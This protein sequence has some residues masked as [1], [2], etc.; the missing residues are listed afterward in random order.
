MDTTIPKKIL[1]CPLDWGIGHASRCVPIIN[2]LIENNCNV[3]IAAD[4][5]PLAFLKKEF[6]DLAYIKFPGYEVSYLH[7][8]SMTLKILSSIPK[9]LRGIYR[10]NKFLKII[11]KRHQIDAVI[12]D[13]RFGLWNRNVRCVYLTHQV[14]IKTSWN[15][16]ILD[17]LLYKI[18]KFFIKKYNECWIPDYEG[19]VN[20]SGD[21]SHK[22]KKHGNTFFIGPLSRFQSSFSV[23]ESKIKLSPDY[24][25]D[26]LAM[27]SGPEPQRTIFEEKIIAELKK[28]K[29]KAIVLRGVT[30]KEEQDEY[31]KNITIFSHLASDEI[32]NFIIQSRIVICRSGYSS[33]MDLAALGK[34]A[35][36]IPTPGQTEQEYLAKYYYINRSFYYMSQKKFD[37][38][39]ALEESSEF[40]GFSKKYNPSLLNERILSLLENLTIPN[41]L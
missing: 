6:P 39:K 5:R 34:N 3:I 20:F 21:L 26:I 14:M 4:H 36:F 41:K 38:E 24:K 28:N 22:F 30:E 23:G 19:K 35:I 33:I 15:F 8:G 32:K 37:L 40:D 11:I 31:D 29:L 16:K 25:Y 10:E 7:N 12:S 18:H 9:I 27:I 17:Y 2:K 13:N 1:I